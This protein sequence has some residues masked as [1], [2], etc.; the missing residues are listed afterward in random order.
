MKRA[1]WILG[2]LTVVLLA[3]CGGT[4]R[5]QGTTGGTG[6]ESGSMGDTT[7]MVPGPTPM[8]TAMTGTGTGPDSVAD[9]V[10]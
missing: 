3:G 9:S 5:D 4:T 6:T 10:R 2:S 8:D 1:S 7:I